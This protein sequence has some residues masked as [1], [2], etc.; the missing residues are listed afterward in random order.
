MRDQGKWGAAIAR[1]ASSVS[2]QTFQSRRTKA[3]SP[4]I[5]T[6]LRISKK[7]AGKTYPSSESHLTE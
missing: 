2:L 7:P 1:F 5:T 3:T 4:S 6:S